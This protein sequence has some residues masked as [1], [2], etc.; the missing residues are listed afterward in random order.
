MDKIAQKLSEVFGSSPFIIVHIIWF[1]A[2]YPLGGNTST[3]T[4]IVSLEAIFLSLFILRAEN[5]QNRKTDD[6]I[7]EIKREVKS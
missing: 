4:V 6:N 5:V 2:W 1:V 3:L 7:K